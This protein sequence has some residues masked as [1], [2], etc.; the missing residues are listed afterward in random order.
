M[1]HKALY[2]TAA[3]QIG[4]VRR[5]LGEW[6]NTNPCCRSWPVRY[7]R[8]A[9]ETDPAVAPSFEH[10][11]PDGAHPEAHLMLSP[12]W[13]APDH[14]VSVGTAGLLLQTLSACYHEWFVQGRVHDGGI[15]Y[16]AEDIRLA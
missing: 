12:V 13:T 9:P 6:V 5:R 15:I 1:M 4:R 16:Q 7:G 8:N 10:S 3:K 11:Q 2:G 14:R